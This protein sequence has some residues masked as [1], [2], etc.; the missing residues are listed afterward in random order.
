MVS[1]WDL[2]SYQDELDFYQDVTKFAGGW[3]LISYQ[4]ELDLERIQMN[5]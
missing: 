2:I 3:D 5:V 1:G 4:D